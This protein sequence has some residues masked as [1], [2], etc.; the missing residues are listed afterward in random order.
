VQ[1]VEN[2]CSFI[3]VFPKDASS[4]ENWLYLVFPLHSALTVGFGFAATANPRWSHGGSRHVSNAN[5]QGHTNG[6][7]SHEVP[8]R[9]RAR[10]RGS[11][12]RMPATRMPT[13]GIITI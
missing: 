12:R 2:T 11:L 7:W 8:S 5:G 13:M 9:T 3:N 6:W 1:R 10:W 4:R